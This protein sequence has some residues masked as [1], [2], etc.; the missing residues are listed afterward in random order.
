[1]NWILMFCLLTDLLPHSPTCSIVRVNF[2]TQSECVKTGESIKDPDVVAWA[3][4]QG[5]SD[6]KGAAGRETEG[7]QP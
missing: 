2:T 1:M 5:H 7:K 6:G 4:V 3:C